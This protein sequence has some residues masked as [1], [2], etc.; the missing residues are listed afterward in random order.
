MGHGLPRFRAASGSCPPPKRADQ[1]DLQALH[2]VSE[3]LVN[4][5]T[6]SRSLFGWKYFLNADLVNQMRSAQVC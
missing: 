5:R 6:G 2:R 4:Q 1:L 3:R